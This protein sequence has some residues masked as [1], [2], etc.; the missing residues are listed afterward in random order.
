METPP[1]PLVAQEGQLLVNER[2]LA[3]L[4]ETA[5][6]L[7]QRNKEF[8]K[9]MERV[10]EDNAELRETLARER[11][12][13]ERHQAREEG[14][15]WAVESGMMDRKDNIIRPREIPYR[16]P[17]IFRTGQNF[18]R[19]LKSFKIFAE[20][21]QIPEEYRINT[22]ITFLDGPAQMKV[23]TL[24]LSEE[25]KLHPTECF[26]KIARAIEGTNL[27]N[28]CRAKLFNLRQGLD[29]SVT[30]F[31]TKLT[32]LAD[33]VYDEPQSPIKEQIMLD[34]FIMGLK[35]DRL[36]FDLIKEEFT[37]FQSAY[38]KALDLES[39]YALRSGNRG[40]DNGD[41]VFQIKEEQRNSGCTICGK[42]NHI[43]KNCFRLRCR[44]CNEPGHVAEI[45]KNRNS[46]RG[47]NRN[48]DQGLSLI[49]I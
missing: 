45:C 41:N 42:T 32:D 31:A 18:K 19:W 46:S 10:S 14:V 25:N 23:E 11:A 7:K 2:E 44:I 38:Q 17:D 35:S 20:T 15:R 39:I 37:D 1:E 16:K 48:A 21:A 29:E 34:C 12:E 24:N 26:E 4:Q 47:P 27:K 49:H 5:E 13:F 30:D 36:A 22:L 3:Q 8:A 28:D 6:I 33:R 43:W 9:N 40:E